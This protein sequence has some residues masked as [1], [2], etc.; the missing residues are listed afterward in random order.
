MTVRFAREEDYPA[1]S[2]IYRPYVEET[3]VSFEYEAPSAQAFAERMRALAGVHPVLVCEEGGEILGYAYTADAFERRAYAWSAEL[4]VYVQRDA[5]GKGIGRALV[6]RAELILKKLGYRKLYALV[7]EENGESLAFH[8]A[9]GYTETA[10][11]PEQGY[12]SG[13]WLAVVWLEKE[14][15]GGE[16]CSAFPLP[17]S[18]LPEEEL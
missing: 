3:T 10:R 9:M 6:R 15:N 13:K 12:K 7:T 18:A 17:F 14:L 4:S 11:F 16:V 5:R 2:E 1:M 8:R